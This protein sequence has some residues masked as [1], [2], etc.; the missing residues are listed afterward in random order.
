[1]HAQV[2]VRAAEALVIIVVMAARKAALDVSARA[3]F[4]L[5]SL[6]VAAAAAVVVLVRG[7]SEGSPVFDGFTY[8]FTN[9]IY[10]DVDGGGFTPPGP[11]ALPEVP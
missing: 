5:G 11:V 6:R 2:R 8:A 1:M 9:P 10:V 3:G 4:G 7:P